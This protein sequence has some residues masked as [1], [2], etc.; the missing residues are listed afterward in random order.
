MKNFNFWLKICVFNFFVVSVVAVMMRYNMAFSLSGFNHK[1]MQESH[2]HFA[3]YGWVSAGIFL[4]VTKYLSE[5]YPK[6]NLK[7]YQYLMISNQIG[8]YGMLFTFLYGG[9]FWLSI[10]LSS[11]ALF[12]GFAYF[13]FLLI[14][15]KSNKNPEIMWLKSGAFFATISAIG[16]F[17]LAYFSTKKDEFEVLFR[18]STYFYLHYQYNGFFIFSCI[19]LLLISLKKLGIEIEEKLNKTIFYLLFFG[20]FLGYGLS[21]LWI[22]MNPIFYGFFIL[23][24]IVQL[25]GVILF[26]NWIRK[27]DLFNNQNFIQKLLISVFGFAFI[28]KFL[29]QGLSAIP[30]LGIF[31]FSNI[32]IVIAYLHLVLLMGISLFLIWKILQLVEIE[33]N[34]LLKFSILLLVF[35]IVCNEIVLA[36]SGIFSIFYIPFLSAKYWLLFVSVVIMISIG[37]FIKSLKL[38]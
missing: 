15:T 27:T 1:F 14:D 24:S 19:G 28:L 23:I 6:I 33:F 9:Y 16:I 7:K 32:N 18:A 11:I 34:K 35:G 5:N 30:A 10:V 36:L 12:T 21:I 8:S 3:F 26:L 13:I 29:L 4:F 31:A 17:G 25:F 2:S 22:E 38:N 37:I 20:C